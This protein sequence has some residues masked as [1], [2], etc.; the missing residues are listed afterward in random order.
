LPEGME[1]AAW[2]R[3]P[4]EVGELVAILSRVSSGKA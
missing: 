4:F 1:G 2:V 3:K